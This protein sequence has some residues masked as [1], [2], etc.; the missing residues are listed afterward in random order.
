MPDVRPKV[1]AW[2]VTRR[3][4]LDCRHCRGAARDCAYEGELSTEECH[5]VIDGITEFVSEAKGP[6][7][8]IFTGGEPMMRDDLVELIAHAAEGGLRTVMAPCGHLLTPDS[9]RALKEAGIQCMS[10]S[11]DGPT[12]E[13][14]D[15][16]RGV[17]GAFGRSVEGLQCAQAA[18]IPIQINTTVTR[19]NVD[20]LSAMLDFAVAHHAMTLDLFFLVPTGRGSALRDLALS[21][22]EAERAL[23]WIA[24]TSKTASIRIK[25]T[26]AP[27]FARIAGPQGGCLAGSG[28]VFISHRGVLQPCGF[29]DVPCGDLR[30]AAFDFGAVYRDAEVFNRLRDRSAYKGK[31]GLCEYLDRC[32]GCRARAYAATGD[33]MEAEDACAY[34][35]KPT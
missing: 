3:C 28:F 10:L 26:C 32:G 6:T 23:Q 7:I 31:C 20:R 16:F 18:G 13:L 14:H 8:L 34:C 15:A 35:P 22:P 17:D 30:E 12:A 5:R 11:F 27:Q 33:Y 9:A 2:E 21:S 24:R 19:L 4:C 25:T 1:I 29:L